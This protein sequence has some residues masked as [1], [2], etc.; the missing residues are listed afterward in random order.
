M[1]MVNKN[2]LFRCDGSAELGMGHIVGSIRFARILVQKFNVIPLFLIKDVIS[3]KEYLHNAGFNFRTLAENTT[4]D[5]QIASVKKIHDEMQVSCIV[6]NF[7]GNALKAWND[8]FLQIKHYG[9]NLVF[10]DN[11]MQSYRYADIVINALPHPEYPGYSIQNHPACFDG[12]EYF[13]LDD[14]YTKFVGNRRMP[15]AT[16]SKI[17]IAMG[18]G[19]K[20]NI[21]AYLL[22][23]LA[24]MQLHVC[25][26]VI[27]GAAC[28]HGE[29]ISDLISSLNINAIVHKNIDDLPAKIADADIGFSALGLTT[30]EMAACGLPC[31]LIA[32][33]ELN[34]KVSKLYCDHYQCALYAGTIETIN[35]HDLMDKIAFLIDNYHVRNDIMVKTNKIF[36]CN[37]FDNVL[38]AIGSLLI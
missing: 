38:S 14:K 34:A 8:K 31:V 30:Y 3:V 10:Q 4:V 22:R 27:L 35:D 19:D 24:T 23:I 13:L 21:T 29:M 20:K 16:V 36:K 11:P 2:V 33:N 5:K 15:R 37:G 6:F 26:D 28:P 7:D 12:L 17:I 1:P 25:I 32:A 9:I 18:A